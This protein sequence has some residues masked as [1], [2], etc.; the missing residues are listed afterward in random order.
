MITITILLLILALVLIVASGVCVILIDP[1][2]AVLAIYGIY[3][4]VKWITSRG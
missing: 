4:I 1:I 2:I 3:R